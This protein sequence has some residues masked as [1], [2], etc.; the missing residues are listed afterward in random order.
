MPD[1][2]IIPSKDYIDQLDKN[3]VGRWKNIITARRDAIEAQLFL[4]EKLR[5]FPSEDVDIV[6]FGSLARQ[7]WT[8]GSDVDWT[9]LIDGQANI[10]HRSNAREI[11]LTLDELEFKGKR[12]NPPG[13][14][15]IFGNMAFSH[16][17]VHHI[18]GQDDTNRNMTQRILLLL[19][20]TSL[21][22]LEAGGDGPCERT[23]RQILYRYL[24]GDS[25]FHPQA[26]EESRIPRFLLNDIVRFWRTMCVDFAYKDWEQAGRKWALRNIK[27]RTSRKLLF[28]A[29]MLTVFS[30]FK[31]ESLN[32]DVA[33]EGYIL[34][35]Q[36]HLLNYVHSTPLNI[37]VWTL[38]NMG[39]DED[40][41]KIL[42][43]YEKFLA[44]MNDESL[45]QH[46][47]ELNQETVYQDEI[48]LACREIS[49]QLQIVLQ[50]ICFK[51]ESP[52]R[53]FTCEYGVF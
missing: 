45:R 37:I 12:L 53:E 14:E 36:E 24:K 3:S 7:E 39:R 44:T 13:G 9:L 19:E 34:K 48:F 15:G 33:P 47:E 25:N 27:L 31:N 41:L 50:N 26:N 43:I 2:T 46:L 16:E 52:L 8:T 51:E 35:L 1:N 5:K 20:A 10:D 18:G 38:Q 21:R 22:G 42:D 6:V 32:H 4:F 11:G 29:G 30:C 40:C 28:V 23:V 49:H 17:I